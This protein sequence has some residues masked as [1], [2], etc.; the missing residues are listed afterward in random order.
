VKERKG[1]YRRPGVWTARQATRSMKFIPASTPFKCGSRSVPSVKGLGS[2]ETTSSF[3][4]F[5]QKPK[6]RL[7]ARNPPP[8]G[9]H[10]CR[11]RAL[12]GNDIFVGPANQ[13]KTAERESSAKPRSRTPAGY[14]YSVGWGS[15]FTRLVV[16]TTFLQIRGAAAGSLKFNRNLSW[17]SVNHRTWHRSRHASA[18]AISWWNFFAPSA[19]D[20]GYT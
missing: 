11:K 8:A 13:I 20:A 2:S 15:S 3:R 16:P 12:Q 19:P 1:K 17:R 10:L 9:D 5:G 7:Q 14:V 6:T 18:P 4:V